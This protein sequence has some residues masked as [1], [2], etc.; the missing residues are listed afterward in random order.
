ME[1]QAMEDEGKLGRKRPCDSRPMPIVIPVLWFCNV[2][3]L[4]EKVIKQLRS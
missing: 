2:T 4:S 3:E 1:V